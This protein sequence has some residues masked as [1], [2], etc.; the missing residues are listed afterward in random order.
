MRSTTSPRNEPCIRIFCSRPSGSREHELKKPRQSESAS[1]DFLCLLCVIPSPGR[2]GLLDP[3][4]VAAQPGGISRGAWP[5]LHPRSNEGGLST[6]SRVVPLKKGVAKGLPSGFA[7]P[8]EIQQLAEIFVDL[9]D[10]RHRSGL[11][12]DRAIRT[13][14]RAGTD[15]TGGTTRRQRFTQSD[16]FERETMSS[17]LV[18][19]R[20]RNWR[21]VEAI[22]N[23]R[24][25]T[26]CRSGTPRSIPAGVGS[27][28]EDSIR[29]PTAP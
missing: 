29:E 26:S 9:Q 6:R 19:G 16:A 3:T 5:S 10:K 14:G 22:I 12:F 28:L 11:R 27:I 24:A 23:R 13:L 18:C 20:G 2:R 1:R 7:I 4:G 25:Q 21:I 8:Q 17:S 15:K